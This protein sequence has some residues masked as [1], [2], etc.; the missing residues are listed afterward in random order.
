MFSRR[1]ARCN[2]CTARECSNDL[3]FN[4]TN[5]D[6]DTVSQKI[7]MTSHSMC[8]SEPV[9]PEVS[10]ANR[11]SLNCE[12]LAEN[13]AC[14]SPVSKTLPASHFLSILCEHY[15]APSSSKSFES[16]TLRKH[17]PKNTPRTSLASTVL[18]M[19]YTQS[20]ENIRTGRRTTPPAA[21]FE[22]RERAHFL[23]CLLCSLL[24]LTSLGLAQA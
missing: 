9:A 17:D 24:T 21:S 16:N 6:P 7:T 13:Y 23:L 22:R 19:V 14:N 18:S 1:S 20:L 11:L 10:P 12:D 2:F 3:D 8:D 5:D 4:K 15:I